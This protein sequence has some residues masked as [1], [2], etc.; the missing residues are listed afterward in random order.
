M[1]Y[2]TSV[3]TKR[4]WTNPNDLFPNLYILKEMPDGNYTQYKVKW[5]EDFNYEEK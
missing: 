1:I 4:G 3:W 2:D 5:V